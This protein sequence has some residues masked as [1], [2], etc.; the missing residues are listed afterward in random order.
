MRLVAT[1]TLCTILVVLGAT[2]A[3]ASAR[4]AHTGT[5]YWSRTE[6]DDRV[7]A[8]DIAL[9]GRTVRLGQV[10]CVGTG[11]TRLKV[12]GVYKYQHFNCLITP[13]RERAFWILVHTL[14]RGWTY[15]FMHFA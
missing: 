6:A 9:A 7:G 2:A 3:A 1:L 14:K 12:R 11:R 4:S 10:T 8:G 13:A 5:P 15:Q